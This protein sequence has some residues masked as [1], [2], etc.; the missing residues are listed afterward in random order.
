MAD[1]DAVDDAVDARKREREHGG[2]NVL[3]VF[4]DH[5]AGD[6]AD[7]PSRWCMRQ[8]A[9]VNEGA[10]PECGTTPWIAG[11]MCMVS[12]GAR[13]SPHLDISPERRKAAPCQ[14]AWTNARSYRPPAHGR[15]RCRRVRRKP[16]KRK[17]GTRTAR[18]PLR[19][20]RTSSVCSACSRH[21]PSL[22]AIAFGIHFTP[23]C[24]C[25]PS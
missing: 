21:S 23:K 22:P 6:H 17:T 1:E 15:D 12:H 20:L 3:E 2:Q 19:R 16:S 25:A 11:L 7:S 13:T 18:S 4:G 9:S 10:E 14:A 5:L 8:G 24:G